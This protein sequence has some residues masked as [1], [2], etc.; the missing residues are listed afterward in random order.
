MIT[1]SS[2]EREQTS[3]LLDESA[4]EDRIIMTANLL[5][6]IDLKTLFEESQR[7]TDIP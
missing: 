2:R 4:S 1:V 6:I 3:Q 5:K 7:V